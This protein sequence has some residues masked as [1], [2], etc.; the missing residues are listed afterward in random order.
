MARKQKSSLID[1]D[2]DQFAIGA[3]Q[4]SQAE[5]ENGDIVAANLRALQPIYFAAILEEARGYDVVERLVTMF[6]SGMLPLGRE[7]AGALVR[8]LR[9]APQRARREI[10][11]DRL[12]RAVEVPEERRRVA[13]RG[14]RRARSG[15]HEEQGERG[16][17]LHR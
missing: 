3:L 1:T 11:L 13:L 2:N 7:R 15:Q 16:A 17:R 5:D 9:S 6:A 10:E 4:V 8:D 14:G 12:H